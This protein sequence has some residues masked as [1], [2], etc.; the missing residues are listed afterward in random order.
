MIYW[1][2]SAI[3][4]AT[5]DIVYKKSLELSNWKISDKYYNFIWNLFMLL[6]FPVVYLFFEFEWITITIF[7]L[8]VLASFFK[9]IWELFEQTAIKNEKLSVLVP[10]WEFQSIFTVL[11]GFFVFSQNSRISF[12]C[13]LLAWL[14]LVIWSVDFKKFKFNK[15]C[16]TMILS[17]FFLA[18]KYIIYWFVLLE[19]SEY[20]TLFYATIISTII[21]LLIIVFSKSLLEYKNINKKISKY[22]FWENIIRLGVSFITLF[23]IK[24]LWIVQAVLIWMIYLIIS[25]F[26]SFIFLKDKPEKKAIIIAVIVFLLVSFWWFFWWI[27][28]T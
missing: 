20:S 12:I 25:L 10:Y 9:I 17:S 5:W 6:F 24:E 22:I 18:L 15:Y 19:I 7:Y 14:T 3:L 13:A 27:V 26:F 16:L 2:L 8:I 1:I 4:W 21:L 23:L 28:E 11:I